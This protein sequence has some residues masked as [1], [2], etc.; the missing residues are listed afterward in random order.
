MEEM[1]GS[2]KIKPFNIYHNEQTILGKDT[3]K[4]IQDYERI[5]KVG[6]L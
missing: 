4:G 5:L 3:H 1:K 2:R 6:T